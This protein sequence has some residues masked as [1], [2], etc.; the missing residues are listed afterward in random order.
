MPT[1]RRYPFS[2]ASQWPASPAAGR[3][4]RKRCP[5]STV[6]AASTAA[7]GDSADGYVTDCGSRARFLGA[8]GGGVLA[9]PTS[10]NVRGTTHP[11]SEAKS[12]M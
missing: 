8:R 9:D 6:A 2:A 7:S 12:R 11:T 1:S 3:R 10:L 4:S 5:P